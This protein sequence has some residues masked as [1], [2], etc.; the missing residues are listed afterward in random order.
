MASLVATIVLIFFVLI[1][2]TLQGRT[3]L[4]IAMGISVFAIFVTIPIILG[5]KKKTLAAILGA[6]SGVSL[7]TLLAL[8]SGRLMHLS[9]I[10][11]DEM[12]T[13]FYASFADVDLRSL[14]LA[15]IVISALGAIMDVCISIASATEEI[16][17]AHPEI[18]IAKAFRAVFIVSADMMGATVN[19][20]IF[21][22]VGSALPLLLLIALRIE[23]GMP[24]W[25]TFNFTPVLSE[26]VKSAVGC[27]GMFLSMPATA[28]FCIEL[29]RRSRGG[30]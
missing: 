17:R 19:T 3:P 6:S 2:L 4:P 16:F 14:A 5:F 29:H 26:L 24:F 28:F 27:I 20:L 10:V 21:A 22:Y 1:P 30:A 25:L 12:L 13:V 11:T 9:G 18:S 15:G 7:A 8:L 23:P